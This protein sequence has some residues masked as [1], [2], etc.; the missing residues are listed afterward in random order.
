[1]DP[2]MSCRIEDAAGMGL[3]AGMDCKVA[4]SGKSILGICHDWTSI[5]RGREWKAVDHAAL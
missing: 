2:Q 3:K 5:E 1:M 4:E